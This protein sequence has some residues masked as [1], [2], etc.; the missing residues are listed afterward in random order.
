MSDFLLAI[1][2][3][4]VQEF[5][6]AARRTRDLWFGSYLLSEICK[7]AAEA[8][9]PKYLIFPAPGALAKD[10]HAA[11]IILAQ[12]PGT[13]D[14]FRKKAW[15]AAV[16]KWKEF[17]N[18]VRREVEKYIEPKRWMRQ[19]EGVLEFYAA[20]APLTGP[21]E[22]STARRQVMRFLAGRKMCR[23][24]VPWQG[25]AK[26]PKSSLDGARESVWRDENAT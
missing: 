26:V 24:F 4:P 9:G 8:I 12:V 21:A 6:S 3:G 2:I 14:Q 15:D 19:E 23:D 18:D 13:P 5:I 20:W 10:R 1:S 16:A 22:Y 17:V 7:A 11:N 25:E